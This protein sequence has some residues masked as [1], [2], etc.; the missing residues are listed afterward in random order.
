MTKENDWFEIEL[1]EYVAIQMATHA[2]ELAEDKLGTKSMYN[3]ISRVN[4]SD[5]Y[6]DV[7]ATASTP[8]S[9]RMPVNGSTFSGT[10]DAC[11]SHFRSMRMGIYNYEES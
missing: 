1:E 8:I 7:G 9:V 2:R 10:V 4:C 11:R 5:G 6:V 3:G